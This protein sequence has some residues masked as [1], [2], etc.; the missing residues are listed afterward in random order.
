MD[1]TSVPT[2]FALSRAKAYL[3]R[4]GIKG[5]TLIVTGG[6]RISPD[7]ARLTGHND[8]HKLSVRDLGTINS[9]IST[10]TPIEHF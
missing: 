4:K 3:D 6:M 1:A 10:H 5:I 2:V 9:E 7:F 8:V